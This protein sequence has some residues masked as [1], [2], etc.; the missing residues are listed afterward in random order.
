MEDR[1]MTSTSERF[2]IPAA[3]FG[4]LV[5]VNRAKKREKHKMRNR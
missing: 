2:G 1:A 5:R 3:F 4:R